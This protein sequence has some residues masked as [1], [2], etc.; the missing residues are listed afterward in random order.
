MIAHANHTNSS[1]IHTVSSLIQPYHGNTTPANLPVSSLFLSETPKINPA[2]TCW[3]LV[4]KI[5][6]N[7]I[8]K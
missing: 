6:M 3:V 7:Y 5:T 4:I 1:A 8:R 2:D